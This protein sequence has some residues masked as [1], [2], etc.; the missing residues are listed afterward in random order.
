M[1]ERSEQAT[2][3]L[4]AEGEAALNVDQAGRKAASETTSPRPQAAISAD[5]AVLDFCKYLSQLESAGC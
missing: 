4:S 5:D 3:A 1:R 2:R